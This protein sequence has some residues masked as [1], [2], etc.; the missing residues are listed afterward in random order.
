[1]FRSKLHPTLITQA[2]HGKLAGALA[3]L[4][5]NAHFDRP[6]LA[7]SSFVAGVELHD[8]GYGFL[9]NDGIGEA[10][11]ERWMAITRTGFYQEFADPVAEMIIKLHL[12]RLVSYGDAPPRQALL[13]ELAAASAAYAQQHGLDQTL[14]VRVDRITNLCDSIAFDFCFEQPTTGKVAVYPK[15]DRPEPV[16]IDYAVEGDEIQVHPWPFA[17]ASYHGH[18]IA[19]QQE[20]YPA[21]LAPVLRP[22]LL[23]QG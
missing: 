10:P 13:A 2:E 20:G 6:A 14:F 17:V 3:F 16:T 12:Q 15:N 9:D 7:H 21:R 23:R 5:G 22:F 18:L 8:R 19:Y 1:M 11:E 4:W